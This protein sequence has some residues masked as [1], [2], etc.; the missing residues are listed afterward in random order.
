LSGFDAC[1]GG[2]RPRPALDTKA[3]RRTSASLA[4]WPFHALP[5]RKKLANC[6]DGSSQYSDACHTHPTSLLSSVRDAGD[7]LVALHRSCLSES[8]LADQPLL[9][10]FWTALC[11]IEPRPRGRLHGHAHELLFSRCSSARRGCPC[12]G[13]TP[14]CDSVLSAASVLSPA[15]SQGLLGCDLCSG[16]P[17]RAFAEAA[18]QHVTLLNALYIFTSRPRV[19]YPQQRP[20]D[21][22]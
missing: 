7:P 18:K 15:A 9:N 16:N 17:S 12:R 14:D 21:D 2:R 6:R 5:A 3:R 4:I 22:A 1:F 19:V 20:A 13:G 11:S 10:S 8:P